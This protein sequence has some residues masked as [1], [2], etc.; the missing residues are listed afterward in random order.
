MGACHFPYC[1]QGD[2][3]ESAKDAPDAAS[4]P[5]SRSQASQCFGCLPWP[6]QRT[7]VTGEVNDK[8]DTL[9]LLPGRNNRVR[10]SIPTGA[11]PHAHPSRS[12][13]QERRNSGR[14]STMTL[15]APGLLVCGVEQSGPKNVRPSDQDC[16]PLV[17]SAN[18]RPPRLLLRFCLAR[19]RRCRSRFFFGAKLSLLGSR[20]ECAGASGFRCCRIGLRKASRRKLGGYQEQQ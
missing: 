9:L 12:C 10:L 19:G 4:R 7:G 16:G 3:K 14:A 2:R 18:G 15:S 5:C 17:N 13:P 6:P 20:A 1:P 8:A 11:P